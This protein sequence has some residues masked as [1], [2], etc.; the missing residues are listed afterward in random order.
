MREDAPDPPSEITPVDELVLTPTPTLREPGA[1]RATISIVVAPRRDQV[2][3]DDQTSPR[4]RR[5]EAPRRGS[6]PATIV[7]ERRPAA[8]LLEALGLQRANAAAVV[9]AA[10]QPAAGADERAMI[11]LIERVDALARWE[12]ATAD[13]LLVAWTNEHFPDGAPWERAVVP[14][15]AREM[16]QRGQVMR[17]NEVRVAR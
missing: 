8:F 2:H 14:T 16:H 11:L 1:R 10:R 9:P 6:A 15:V 4:G 7:L 17:Q 3:A 5:Y 12:E 13:A